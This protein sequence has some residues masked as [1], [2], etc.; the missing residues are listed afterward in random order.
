MKILRNSHCRYNPT[1]EKEALNKIYEVIPAL[2][3]HG[4]YSSG[5]IISLRF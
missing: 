3:N 4:D 1:T 2:N 5:R